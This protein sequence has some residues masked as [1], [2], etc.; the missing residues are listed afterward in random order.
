MRCLCCWH[1]LGERGRSVHELRHW[2][3]R[4]HRFYELRALRRWQVQR[5]HGRHHM[6]ELRGWPVRLDDG[7]L[8]VPVVRGGQILGLDGGH[9]RHGLHLV[10]PRHH[11]DRGRRFLCRLVAFLAPASRPEPCLT[12]TKQTGAPYP[13]TST[14]TRLLAHA[15]IGM[16][17]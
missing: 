10:W 16:A 6:L 15:L 7:A 8:R 5:R 9:R 3:V 1:L 13:F 14:G 12:T 11:L 17:T 4:D 2:Q